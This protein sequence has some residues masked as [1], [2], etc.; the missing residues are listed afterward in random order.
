MTCRRAPIYGH[1]SSY[2]AAKCPDCGGTGRSSGNSSRGGASSAGAYLPPP[3]IAMEPTVEESDLKMEKAI[4]YL[5]QLG[6]GEDK[7]EELV[8]I[9]TDAAWEVVDEAGESARQSHWL[10]ELF[11]SAAKF[12]EE[13]APNSLA[14]QAIKLIVE[15]ALTSVG[16]V[17]AADPCK[18]I[19]VT[20]TKVFTEKLTSALAVPDID[21]VVMALRLLAA[22]V[23]P[24]SCHASEESVSAIGRTV[25]GEA[26][27]TE[28]GK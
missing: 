1:Q 28:A 21:S 5:V 18:A 6:L 9:L 2:T 25:T 27:A 17:V 26:L 11:N 14:D 7:S 10:C 3:T 24:N 16:G 12:L 23:C 8:D 4:E 20:A 15:S 19:V 22:L 13:N